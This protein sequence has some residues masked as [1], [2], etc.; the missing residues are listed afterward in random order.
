MIAK[1][2]PNATKL[3]M[4]SRIEVDGWDSFGNQVETDLLSKVGNT[5]EPEPDVE[6]FKKALAKAKLAPAPAGG[7]PAEPTKPRYLPN[8]LRAIIALAPDTAD[9]FQSVL[10]SA[11]YA[12]PE[13]MA[14]WWQEATNILNR[15]F[16]N[17]PK[18]QEIAAIFNGQPTP[19]AVSGERG[20]E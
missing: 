5:S 10:G 15:E 20:M 8:V 14:M 9:A 16:A 6:S 18:A 4:F 2:Y 3:E 1:W 12:A 7:K 13:N 11:D 19:P 17:H